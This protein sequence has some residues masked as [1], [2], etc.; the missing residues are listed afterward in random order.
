M[1]LL[2]HFVATVGDYFSHIVPLSFTLREWNGGLDWTQKWTLTYFM[3]WMAW[4]PFVG[5]FIAR[6]SRGR[7]IRQFLLG[8]LLVPA[9]FSLFWFAVIG[10]NAV[11][12]AHGGDQ[13]LVDAVTQDYSTATYA[14]LDRMP[15]ASI[16]K[17]VALFLV[18]V[19]LVTSADSGSYVLGM[20]S[21][22][23]AADPPVS[24][25]LFWGVII[26]VLLGWTLFTGKGLAI[27]RSFVA[28]GAIPF[29]FIMVWQSLCLIRRLHRDEDRGSS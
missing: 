17:V 22:K 6:I 28:V 27:M 1:A 25:R 15:F 21:A 10:G 26:A 14:M 4:G 20:F 9:F 29:M 24:L 13:A 7:T 18:F 16:T 11:L 3:W 23:G 8:V 19:F 2:R 12:M 5:V